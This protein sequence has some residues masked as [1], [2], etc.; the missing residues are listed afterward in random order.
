MPINGRACCRTT[1]A[2]W[3]KS[4]SHTKFRNCVAHSSAFTLAEVLVT[5]SILGILASII[6]PNVIQQYQKRV[7]ITKLKKAY[8]TLE[9]AA[10]NLASATGCMGKGIECTGLME[11]SDKKI[12]SDRF[13]E[14]SGLKIISNKNVNWVYVQQLT[15][16][17]TLNQGVFT[18]WI[19][20]AS[21]GIV[22]AFQKRKI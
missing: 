4:A 8:A 11:I 17:E 15:A 21:N 18:G 9:G 5:L 12:F 22:Y 16:N 19:Y 20:T 2:L 1:P 13:V 3:Q 6:V 14:L 7:T 10:A